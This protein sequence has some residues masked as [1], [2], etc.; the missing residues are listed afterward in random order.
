MFVTVTYPSIKFGGEG[1]AKSKF[2]VLE[3]IKNKF[4]SVAC[5]GQRPVPVDFLDYSKKL[6]SPLSTNRP[7]TVDTAINNTKFWRGQGAH[8]HILEKSRGP[9]THT[10]GVEGHRWARTHML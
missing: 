6:R 5:T 9:H 1:G 7:G 8:I 4:V 3:Y 2:N 10:G